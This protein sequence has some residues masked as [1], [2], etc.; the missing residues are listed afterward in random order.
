MNHLFLMSWLFPTGMCVSLPGCVCVRAG[1]SVHQYGPRPGLR[2]LRGPEDPSGNLDWPL[3]GS[4]PVPGQTAVR[5]RQEQQT[6]VGGRRS[7]GTGGKQRAKKNKA[8]GYKW[9][10]MYSLRCP[11]VHSDGLWKNYNVSVF[12]PYFFTTKVTNQIKRRLRD[13]LTV[14]FSTNFNPNV[15]FHKWH[16]PFF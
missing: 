14:F 13:F 7:G 10:C 16:F 4:P 15:Y 8:N 1:V 6:P 2:D 11:C 9:W 5:R 12:F 3:P